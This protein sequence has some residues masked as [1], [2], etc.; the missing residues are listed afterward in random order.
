[1]A[2]QDNRA[3]TNLVGLFIGMMIAAI[4]GVQVVIPILNDAINGSNVTGTT[5]T[6][7]GLL[8]MFIALMLLVGMA[9]PLMRRL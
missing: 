7:L 6:I 9:S 3:Q 1:M 5:E 4:V 2:L 8:P